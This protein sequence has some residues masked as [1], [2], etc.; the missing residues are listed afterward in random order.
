MRGKVRAVMQS[1]LFSAA[2]FALGIRVASAGLS[3]ASMVM[4]SRWIGPDEY[5]AFAVML[6]L[7][8]FIGLA[9]TLGLPTLVL[10]VIPQLLSHSDDMP[11]DAL[12]G[13]LKTSYLSILWCGA[14]ASVL[15]AGYGF[16]AG[17]VIA[18]C[19]AALILPF[20]YA[21]HQA[22]AL[23]ALNKI[24]AALLPRDIYWY[25]GMTLLGAMGALSILPQ[26]DAASAF[27]LITGV[28]VLFM[29]LQGS[30]VLKNI[31]SAEARAG[32]PHQIKWRAEAFFL[33]LSTMSQAV[34]RHLTVVVSAPFLTAAET[35]AFFAAHRTA[36]LLSLPL[37]AAN[38][39]ASPWI[40]R[41]WG[42]GNVTRVQRLCKLISIGAAIP[43]LL[44]LVV[45]FYAGAFLLGLFDPSFSAAIGAL[46]VFAAA[47]LVNALCGPT[48][49]LM[50]MT[51][52]EKPFVGIQISAQVLSLLVVAVAA[53][54]YGLIGAALGA[55]FG[56]VGWNVV[57]WLWCRRHIGVDPAVTSWV[58]PCRSKT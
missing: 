48:G 33:W 18:M 41:A 5:G 9:A 38:L 34:Q 22:H 54:Q 28:L 10:R 25:G 15:L 36:L 30:S 56:T 24:G 21:E 19:A 50:L 4:I 17:N 1:R 58:W 16:I 40:A 37:I 43:A 44:G 2:A 7:G 51:G 3:F 13:L 12:R 46:Y 31:R 57:V 14:A 6:T 47:S 53:W 42:D 32:I 35:G 29:L 39:V 26:A 11:D 49:G 8:S 52:N 45:I 20:A 55:A 27:L 23:R